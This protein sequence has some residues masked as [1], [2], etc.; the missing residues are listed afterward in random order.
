MKIINDHTVVVY[1]S[2]ELKTALE[3]DNN[4]T[5]IYL[6]NNISLDTGIKI[7]PTKI[8][9]IIDGTYENITYTFEDRKTLSAS[10]TINI[11]STQITKVLVCNM[12]IIGNN[13]YGVI[14]VPDSS[15]YK[16]TII[17]YNNITYTGPQISFHPTGLTT[18]I[19]STITIQDNTLT[20]GNEVAECNQ[21]ILG[22][23][24]N[25]THKSK[26]NSSFWFRNANPSLTVLSNSK[27]TFISEYRELIYG[28]NNLSFTI[29]SNSTM[30]ITTNNGMSY[31]TNG[32]ENTL[33]S[34]SSTLIIKQTARNGNYATWYSYGSITINKNAS[35]III[36]DFPNITAQNYN[37]Y[38]SN[39]SSFILNNPEKVVLYNSKA[40]V[41]YTPSS[42][43]FD[44]EF[45]R[46]NLFS[47][48]I[49]ITDPISPS[50][51][52]EYSWYKTSDLSHITGSFTSTTTTI[53]TNNY[54]EEELTTLP[55]LTNLIFPNKKIFSI[56]SFLFRV[57][58]IT[59]ES[60]TMTGS[61]LP[62]SSILISYN[63]TNNVITSDSSGNF[64]YTYSP[65][66]PIDTVITF[67][68]KEYNDLL[69]HTKTVKIVYP[70]EL[71]IDSATKVINFSLSPI[72][73]TPLICPKTTSL[74][75][76]I[77]DTRANSTDWR[78]YAS[79]AHDLSSPSGSILENSLIYKDSSGVISTLSTNKTLIYTGKKN[80]G[81]SLTTDI[82]FSAEEGILL[83]INNKVIS[84]TEYQTDII[85]SLEE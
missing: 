6:G 3:N 85:W 62:L 70:G 52:P 17:E 79:I 71:A 40:N 14:Y 25:I 77:I 81:T 43:P 22:G 54:T 8:N 29:L 53:T 9:L 7:S 28:V 57:N 13:Y 33:I 48:P 61:T 32:T 59:D 41:I 80:D 19:D 44:F 60:T 51:L 46:L 64:T 75:L 38:F 63:E 16:N 18:F 12:N 42:I 82:T 76:K 35:L 74:S 31:G 55:S 68:I 36:N 4:Y 50:T 66:L 34:P 72:S 20:A 58:A 56:G 69:Y 11:S 45:S 30:S 1:S 84:N 49:T 21:I 10:D 73:T 26:S 67:N 15:I 83:L 39:K 27:I 47:N 24:T 65:T 2:T 78:L 37:I 23:T 5:Y